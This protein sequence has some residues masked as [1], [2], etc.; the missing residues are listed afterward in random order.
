VAKGYTQLQGIDFLDTFSP[1]A[2]LTTIR[3]LLALAATKNWHLHQLDVDNAFLHG[4]LNEE[5]YMT[6]PSSLNT[7]GRV[8]RLRKSLYGLKQTNRQWF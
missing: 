3:L 5:V 2:K 4:D 1:I 7:Q 8:C 6:P